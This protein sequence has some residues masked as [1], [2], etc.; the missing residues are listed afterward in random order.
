MPRLEHICPRCQPHGT[1][2][3][4]DVQHMLLHCSQ[5]QR[6]RPPCR[7][8]CRGTELA[9]W[10]SLRGRPGKQQRQQGRQ[11]GEGSA[12][13]QALHVFFCPFFHAWHAQLRPCRTC[14]H[15]QTGWRQ[16]WCQPRCIL[17]GLQPV[18][19][20]LTCLDMRSSLGLWGLQLQQSDTRHTGHHHRCRQG[21][22][23]QPMGVATPGVALKAKGQHVL[24]AEN[25]ASSTQVDERDVDMCPSLDFGQLAAGG[26]HGQGTDGATGSWEAP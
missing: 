16:R 6:Q 13:G 19:L 2:A 23:R 25:R 15:R 17:L 3:I 5:R 8:P 4:E 22:R 18:F 12:R 1:T 9:P 21:P 10:G 11:L 24:E 26:L 20:V 14:T 7:L